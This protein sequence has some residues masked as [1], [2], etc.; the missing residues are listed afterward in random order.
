MSNEVV[1]IEVA[2]K[3]DITSN[4]MYV[5]FNKQTGVIT[6]I[7]PQPYAGQDFI[8]VPLFE[9]QQLI[10]GVAPWRNYRVQYNPKVKKFELTNIKDTKVYGNTIN[11]FIYEVPEA[12]CVDPDVTIVQ[13]IPN[14]CWKFFIGHQLRNNLT[15]ANLTNSMM[16]SVTA[17]GDPN[18]LYK[19]LF[20]PLSDI[21]TNNYVVLP[22]TMPFERTNEDIS[23]YT[24]RRFDTY[25]FKRIFDE[26]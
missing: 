14:E 23:V 15:Q 5:K 7:G 2:T 24:A 3:S 10:D 13:D 16:V 11:D 6:G 21:F 25:Q 12:R 1:H 26:Q 8:S 18:V 17:K 9:V 22:F 20:V 19:T 4:L